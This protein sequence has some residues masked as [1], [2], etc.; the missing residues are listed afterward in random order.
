MN[1]QEAEAW[2]HRTLAV[3]GK[4][5][6]TDA[7]R[8]KNGDPPKCLLVRAKATQGRPAVLRTFVRNGEDEDFVLTQKQLSDI[9]GGEVTPTG[10]TVEYRKAGVAARL[11]YTP[12]AI[13]A[14][15]VAVTAWLATVAT[16]V[17]AYLTRSVEA[18]N[19]Q[20]NGSSKA[21]GWLLPV[22]AIAL[23]IIALG[24]TAKLLKDL[25]DA[26]Q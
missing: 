21:A 22:A 14:S 18:S 8:V 10:A 24:A 5:G 1:W 15:I 12:G 6:V 4:A 25:R 13:L 19:A 7:W 11:W 3:D 17:L 23:G 26:R 20:T 2:E 16:A 9:A